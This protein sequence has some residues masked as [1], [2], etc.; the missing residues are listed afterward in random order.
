MHVFGIDGVVPRFVYLGC[1]E[2]A[3]RQLETLSWPAQLSRIWVLGVFGVGFR[4][5]G[6]RGISVAFVIHSMWGVDC[7]CLRQFEQDEHDDSGDDG[8]AADDE[9]DDGENDD[10]DVGYSKMKTMMAMV[11][12]LLATTM[13]VVMILFDWS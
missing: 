13:V 11:M 3:K 9:D 2:Y 7:A 5:S 12:M 8:D 6:L 4:G 10:G 1:Y